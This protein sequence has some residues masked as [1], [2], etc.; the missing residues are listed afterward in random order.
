MPLLISISLWAAFDFLSSVFTDPVRQEFF[1]KIVN[2]GATCSPVFF[3]LFVLQ[4][5]NNLPKLKRWQFAMLFLIP[6]ITFISALTNDLHNLSWDKITIV[7]SFFAGSTIQFHFR[8]IPWIFI[9]YGYILLVFSLI[10]LIR[11]SYNFAYRYTPQVWVIAVSVL[12][13]LS[14]NF[15]FLFFP[16]FVQGID[17]TPIFFSFAGILL[18]TG[19]K[20]HGLLKI[21]PYGRDF[22]FESM[23]DGVLFMDAQNQIIDYNKAASHILQ[24]NF[25]RDVFMNNKLIIKYHPNLYEFCVS[26][27]TVMKEYQLSKI[28]PVYYHIE[29][30]KLRDYWDNTIGKVILMHN[31]TETKINRDIIDRQNEELKLL[32]EQKDKIISIMS[33]DLRSPFASIISLGELM[34]I[35]YS[36]FTDEQRRE[37]ITQILTRTKITYDLLENLLQWSRSITNNLAFEVTPVIIAQQISDT[38]RMYMNHAGDKKIKLSIVPNNKFQPEI[39]ANEQLLRTILRNLITNAIKFTPDNGFI[40]IRYEYLKNQCMISVTDNG[41]GIALS[42]LKLMFKP[43]MYIT[44]RGTN[45]EA[46]SGL[47]LSLCKDL[48]Q[49]MGGQLS[50][51]SKL[52]QGTQVSFTLPYK[53]QAIKQS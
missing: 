25:S 42:K 39:M 10:I 12:I 35:E 9:C 18:L 7:T 23:N 19:M 16:E 50:I 22:L 14:G 17:L 6:A 31:I 32:N 26:D 30:H 5:T 15:A 49:K 24:I 11:T 34:E 48:V 47:G 2:I 37:F 46:G 21:K 52:N 43:D 45:G 20:R 44:S 28:P 38:I 8:L 13:P 29:I 1:V 27:K 36:N 4:Y 33:H 3:L 53:N 51:T 40:E 41:I